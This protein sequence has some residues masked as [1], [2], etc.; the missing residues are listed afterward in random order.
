MSI[1]LPNTIHWYIVLLFLV[2]IV[3]CSYLFGCYYDYGQPLVIVEQLPD[4]LCTHILLIGATNVDNLDVSI[5]QRPYNGS[6]ALQSMRDYRQRQ[7][8]RL[9]V[10]PSLTGDDT[11]WQLAMTNVSTRSQFISALIVFARLQVVIISYGIG[12]PCV[13]RAD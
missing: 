1:T 5:V 6:Q 10:I 12:Q 8:N 4:D 9:K 3:N 13:V 11:Q 7:F 2:S